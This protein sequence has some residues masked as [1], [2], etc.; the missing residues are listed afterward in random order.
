MFRRTRFAP[1]ACLLVLGTLGAAGAT[2]V[3]PLTVEMMA[4]RADVVVRGRVVGQDVGW[5]DD[6]T[7]IYTV[8]RVEVAEA[9]KGGDKAGAILAI[10][11]IGGTVDGL[12]QSVVGNAELR[13]G[14]EL[15]LFLDRDEAQP[16]HYVIGMAQ[17]KFGVSR[18]G[19]EPTVVHDVE[20]LAFMAPGQRT[21]ADLKAAP[22][23]EAPTLKAFEAR[24]RATLSAPSP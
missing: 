19:P 4:Q 11:Q 24:L 1:L 21:V 15:I 5:N 23:G 12:T 6:K 13:A 22:K 10:R 9:Y 2:I 14:E 18:E 3:R 8:T 7:R 16:L 20:G 17:G